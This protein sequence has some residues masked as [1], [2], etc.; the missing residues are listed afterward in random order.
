[1]SKTAAAVEHDDK[2]RLWADKLETIKSYVAAGMSIPRACE[3]SGVK[4]STAKHWL[5]KG[6]RFEQPYVEF[7]DAMLAACAFH[8]AACHLAI[9]S[10]ARRDWRAAAYLLDRR[11]GQ[12]LL[13]RDRGRGGENGDKTVLYYPVALPEG[14]APDAP[15][16]LEHA[17]DTVGETVQ[18]D[19]DDNEGG[20]DD[21]DE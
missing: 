15:L 4:W 11:D 20:T 9:M 16:P 14:A 17:F 13:D 12:K 7:A 2:P 3:A 21:D 19:D 1:M 10:S 6:K 8:E 18:D 5:R